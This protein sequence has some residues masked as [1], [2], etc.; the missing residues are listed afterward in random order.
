MILSPPSRTEYISPRRLAFAA[1]GNNRTLLARAETLVSRLPLSRTQ[2]MVAFY[3]G[4]EIHIV[5][6][7]SD[8]QIKLLSSGCRTHMMSDKNFSIDSTSQ[9]TSKCAVL[10][11]GE[12]V[13][14]SI[15]RFPMRGLELFDR[16]YP[17]SKFLLKGEGW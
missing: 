4:V 8:R 6:T 3:V 12:K 16:L 5:Q 10:Q 2:F 9:L 7:K 14:E 17:P 13:I 1:R 11:G 15:E